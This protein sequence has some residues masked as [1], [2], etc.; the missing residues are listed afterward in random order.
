VPAERSRSA[1]A[2][3][4]ATQV[5]DVIHAH[6]TLAEGLM[7]AAKDAEDKA[8]HHVKKQVG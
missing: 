3:I 1:D 5:A 7:E 8:I 6:P 4:I 2:I